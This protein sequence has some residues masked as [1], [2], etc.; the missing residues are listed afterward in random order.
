MLH[1]AAAGERVEVEGH[2]CE[3]LITPVCLSFWKLLSQNAEPVLQLSRAS[4]WQAAAG[5]NSGYSSNVQPEGRLKQ[6]A[7]YKKTLCNVIIAQFSFSTALL[8]FSDF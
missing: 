1:H 2:G 8:R 5:E 6:R 4:L 3:I 7:A